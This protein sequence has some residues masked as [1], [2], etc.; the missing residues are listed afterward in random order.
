M[1]SASV[2]L[3]LETDFVNVEKASYWWKNVLTAALDG[4]TLLKLKYHYLVAYLVAQSQHTLTH[5]NFQGFDLWSLKYTTH[6]NVQLFC[7]TVWKPS[8][9]AM[10]PSWPEVWSN[11]D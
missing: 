9:P 5:M 8:F 11:K 1:N 4:N 7:Y 6:N 2:G 3:E 10:K